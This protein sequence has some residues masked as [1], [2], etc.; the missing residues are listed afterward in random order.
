[1]KIKAL[2]FPVLLAALPCAAAP[3]ALPCV[4]TEPLSGLIAL[5]STGCTVGDKLF[6]GFSLTSSGT[7]AALDAGLINVLTSTI[8]Q[9]NEV[10][11]LTSGL[12]AAGGVTGGT[13]TGILGYTVQTLSGAAALEDLTLGVG[14]L[15]SVGTG[16]NSATVTEYACAGINV[17]CTAQNANFVLNAVP[18]GTDHAVFPPVTS[19]SVAKKITID[20]AALNVVTLGSLTNE[21]SQVPGQVPEPS[22]LLL[23]GLGLLGGLL[24]GKRRRSA[25]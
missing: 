17:T 18:N 5:G 7:L 12:T 4:G 2:F 14:P 19:L 13:L 22:S 15:T 23:G 3:L 9:G 20:A 24:F 21:V 10:L 16:P 25:R 11:T 8:P 1:M 6:A